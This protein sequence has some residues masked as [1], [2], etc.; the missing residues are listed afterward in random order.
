MLLIASKILVCLIVVF[1]LG[2]AIGYLIGAFKNTNNSK[3]PSS[4][5]EQTFKTHDAIGPINTKEQATLKQLNEV[6][7]KSQEIKK[8]DLTKIKGVGAKIEDSLNE[9]G[10]YTYEQIANWTQEDIDKIN[11]TLKFKGRTSREDWVT[12]AKSLLGI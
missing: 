4:L 1:I 5:D 3:T 12:S 2:L 8:D 6:E 9:L 11:A 7:V 10:I